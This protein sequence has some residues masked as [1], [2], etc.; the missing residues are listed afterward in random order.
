MREPK[1]AVFNSDMRREQTRLGAQRD[2]FAAERL[3]WAVMRLPAVALQRNDLVTDESPCALLQFL[4]L[5][6]KG[7]VHQK[8]RPWAIS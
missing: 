4:Q 1:A 5:R 7:E 3:G 8:A 2:Q 6:R